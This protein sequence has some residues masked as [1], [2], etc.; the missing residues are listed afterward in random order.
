MVGPTVSNLAEIYFQLVDA[1]V[2][3]MSI[4]DLKCSSKIKF[5]NPASSVAPSWP[6]IG[7]VLFA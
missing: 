2:T 7:L 3:I 4:S 6:N 5:L 1:F